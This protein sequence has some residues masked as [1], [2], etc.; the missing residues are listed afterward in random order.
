MALRGLGSGGNG[1][2]PFL[3][4]NQAVTYSY[5]PFLWARVRTQ[6]SRRGPL[7]SIPS[8]V[9]AHLVKGLHWTR[10]QRRV[11]RCRV[12]RGCRPSASPPLCRRHCLQ[13]RPPPWLGSASRPDCSRSPPQPP[14]AV[15]SP[16]PPTP[17]S[18]ASPPPPL[19]R[20]LRGAGLRLGAAA[21]SGRSPFS[22]G[23]QTAGGSDDT[24][25]RVLLPSRLSCALF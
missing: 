14:S 12:V 23:L 6:G 13:C 22:A 8:T 5:C 2:L 10:C 18:A 4:G 19:W 1:R 15:P 9:C 21:P 17:S 7:I 20:I 25:S 24:A 3:C 16:R 11:A